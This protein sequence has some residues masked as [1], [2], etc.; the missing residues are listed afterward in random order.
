MKNRTCGQC[1]HYHQHYVMDRQSCIVVPCGHCTYP[2]LKSRRP[3]SPA[4][5]HFEPGEQ[6][7]PVDR[8][9]LTME[10]LRWI[11]SLEFPP[12]VRRDE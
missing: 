2:R 10:L 9:F 11:Q 7:L 4:C 8:H 5:G 3:D 12:E 6:E 1:G